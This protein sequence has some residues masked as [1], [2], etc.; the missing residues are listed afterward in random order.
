MA[1]STVTLFTA[2]LIAIFFLSLRRIGCTQKK[3]IIFSFLLYFGTPIIFYSLNVSNGQ[4]IL[5][6]AILFIAF[7]IM[8]ISKMQKRSLVFL[9]GLL[10]GLAVFVN[11]TSLFFLPLFIFI[12]FVCLWLKFY[13]K[14]LEG[15]ILYNSKTNNQKMTIH[16]DSSHVPAPT[17][18]VWN[19]LL[20]PPRGADIRLSF[21]FRNPLWQGQ[22]NN[23][24]GGCAHRLAQ[25]KWSCLSYPAFPI[26][27]AR[28]FRACPSPPQ[29]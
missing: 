4:D 21:S 23:I 14:F 11:V 13:A 24:A 27:H 16:F 26:C 20:A 7:F 29:R 12:L 6:A 22:V 28:G 2:L 9:S 3:A 17:R 8:D 18:Q 10:C 19:F 1:L 15:W 25:A 5:Q